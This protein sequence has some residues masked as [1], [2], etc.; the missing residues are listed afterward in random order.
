MEILI[1][2]L[3]VAVVIALPAWFRNRRTRD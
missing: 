3:V 2:V 1:V